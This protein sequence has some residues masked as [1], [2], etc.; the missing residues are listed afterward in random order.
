MYATH[1]ADLDL[2]SLPIEARAIKLVPDMS[3]GTL[4]SVGQLCDAGCTAFFTKTGVSIYH[5]GQEVLTGSRQGPN[6]LWNLHIPASPTPPPDSPMAAANA[7]RPAF[8]PATTS[9]ADIVAFMHGSLGSPV[10]STLR[11]A[12][13]LGYL[14][15]FPGLTPRTIR[16]HPP[17]SVATVKGH[18]DATR[19]NIQS[20]KPP[21]EPEPNKLDF[22]DFFPP[23]EKPNSPTHQVFPACLEITGKAYSDL[24]G[25]FV[26]PSSRGHKYVLVVYDY[27]SNHIF[28]EPLTSRQAANI[29]KAYR[30]I[31]ERL[32]SAGLKPQLVLLD[33]ECS[34]LLKGYMH[35]ER[36]DFQLVPPYQHR[37]NAAERAIRTWKNHFI[38]LICAADDGFPLHLWDYLLPQANISLNLLRGSRINP[39]LSAWA[40]IN[41]HFDYNRTPLAPPGTR[42]LAHISS[43][44]RESWAPH[45]TEGWYL[46]PALDS[47]RCFQV[48]IE[49][50]RH[51]RLVERVTWV[52][53]KLH[54]PIPTTTDILQ[55]ALTSLRLAL[56]DPATD[57]T[58]A[59]TPASL[60]DTL[61]ELRTVLTNAD[62]QA[63]RAPLGTPAS[64]PRVAQQPT[65]TSGFQQ[66]RYNTRSAARAAA[67]ACLPFA[68][69]PAFAYKAFHP[70]TGQLAEYAQLRTSSEG[71][72]WELACARELAR[73]LQGLPSVDVPTGRDTFRFIKKSSVPSAKTVTYLRIV[74][75]FRPQKADPYRIRF[76]VG[77]DRLAYHGDTATRTSDL[78]T[79][80][81]AVNAVLSHPTRKACT[82]DI[83]D[84]YLC[85]RLEE[86]EYMRI[87]ASLVPKAILDHYNLH[88]LIASDGYLYV[89]IDG[90][91]YGL[92][93]AGHIANQAL[94]KHLATHDFYQCRR[95]P[96][97][98]RHRTR[99]LFFPLIVD[100]FFVGYSEKHDVEFLATCLREKYDLTVDWHADIFSGI[101][102]AW[103]YTARTCDLSMPGY[104]EKALQR[105]EHPAPKRP[106]DSPHPWTAPVYGAKTQFT[107]PPDT[108]PVL[109]PSARTRIQEI[110][111]TL[112]FYARAIDDTMLLA[113]NSLASEQ[114]TATETT[115]DKIVQLLNYAATHPDTTIRY[116]AS[117]MYLWVHSDASY[118]SEPQARSRYA[119]YFFLSDRPNDPLQA[120]APGATPPMQ[121]GPILVTTHR[122]KEC[123]ASA[124]EAELG[125]LFHNGREAIPIRT[126]LEELGHPQGPTPIQTDNTTAEGIVTNRVKARRSKAMDMR[127][128]W[129]QDRQ[130]QDQ[131]RIY[132]D[133]GV[134]NL[135]DYFTKH[136]PVSHHRAMRPIYHPT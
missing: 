73:L 56:Q 102:L 2:P 111:G 133:K 63:T 117:D 120:P 98:F 100:D 16:N 99:D 31:I 43:T 41:G 3:A 70:D 93:Q 67:N 25:E 51:T 28:A 6:H 113:L 12:V 74:S 34:A 127:Y 64:L 114:T 53:T 23:S 92:K 72:R 19:M 82:L 88:D 78:T 130:E 86:P 121:N 30:T 17:F 42:V 75:S 69:P 134:G 39:R 124:A 116:R 81:I 85:H 14:H 7:V 118:L 66:H 27:D 21:P 79:F 115:M 94:V 119:G 35:K 15:G 68:L 48:W 105:F 122:L 107:A 45:A 22:D 54:V 24:T 131:F 80:K 60:R 123:V 110:I 29:Y 44:V 136:H 5:D 126:T 62:G 95:T 135:A 89:R 55:E 4:I 106:Q 129:V 132:W 97:L 38:A 91:M 37:R 8:L 9:A 26:I 87:H 49:S 36:I 13:D 32:D 71:A 90:G 59:H 46:G 33:N 61:Q 76:T 83:S 20:T 18:Q 104:V 57:A 101:H 109:P 103:D 128:F 11:K 77:G 125:G 50:T 65:N 47:Y 40:Q 58:I 108:T 96:G 10:V 84:F 112:L 1:Q 52:P